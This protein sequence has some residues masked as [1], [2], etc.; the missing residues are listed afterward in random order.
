MNTIFIKHPI[1][2]ENSLPKEEG[3]Y[4]ARGKDNK[5]YRQVNYHDQLKHHWFNYYDYWLEEKP[6]P[7]EE[8]I[9]ETADLKGGRED[10][11]NITYIDGEYFAGYMECYRDILNLLK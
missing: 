11:N 6:L 10:G 1:T 8:E 3:W 5:I 2:D 7:S 4:I 9:K